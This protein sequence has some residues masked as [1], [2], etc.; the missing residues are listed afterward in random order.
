MTHEEV[1]LFLDIETTG[2]DTVRRIG[3]I[4]DV[5]C[6]LVPWHEIIEI[7]VLAVSVESS[8][9]LKSF[10]IKIKPQH[11]ERCIPN[12]IN[13]YPRRVAKGE[14][15]KAVSLKEGINSFL[16]FCDNFDMTHLIGQNFFFDWSFLSVAFAECNINE[17][18]IKKYIH[19]K[20]IDTAS[21][22]V[23][24]L[25]GTDDIYDPKNFS[26]RGGLIQ[27]H[28]D[29][30]QEP[31]PHTAMNGAMQAFQLFTALKEHHNAR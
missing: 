31:V 4:E 30:P 29:I 16:M 12:L 23:Q 15:D 8:N 9:I 2:H 5:G 18:T 10:E 27:K 14:W 25:L 6:I 1:F 28:L 19:Y 22:A 21:M 7:G 24:E 3:L 20:K 17:E 13:H 26:L 11:P